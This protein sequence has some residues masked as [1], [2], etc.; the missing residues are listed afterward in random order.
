MNAILCL[1]NI[2]GDGIDW[3]Y[4]SN[5][6]SPANDADQSVVAPKKYHRQSDTKQRLRSWLREEK[7]LMGRIREKL[8]QRPSV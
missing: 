6:R 4:G 2:R 1:V 3:S 5:S 8:L 7:E